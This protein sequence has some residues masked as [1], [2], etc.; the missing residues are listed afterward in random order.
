MQSSHAKRSV[1]IVSGGLDSCG[2]ASYWKDRKYQVYLLTFDYGQRSKQE[3]K[4][5]LMI[6][7]LLKAKE[8]KI[9]D[10]SF[11]K[12]LYGASNVL[13]N[14]NKAMP[15]HFRS[16]IIVPI[17]NAVFLTIASAHAFSIRAD[18]VAYGAHLTDQPYP[19][20]RPKFAEQ[21][22]KTLNLGDIDA[23]RTG[24]HPAIK[25]WSP[26]IAGL[27]KA[28]MLKITYGL[29]QEN[30]FKTWSCYLDGVKQCGKCESCNNRKLAFKLAGIE[31]KTEYAI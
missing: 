29:L 2:V 24:S 11:M 23:I 3:I 19:D 7:K 13:T 21:L 18:I 27:S 5:A 14:E 30:V 25:M 9:V 16:N 6:G 10:I 4:S 26:A 15:S 28:E 20:C 17:R 1:I 8:H 12:D 22:S 31:D